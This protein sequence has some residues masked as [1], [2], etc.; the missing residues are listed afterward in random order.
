MPLSVHLKLIS[1]SLHFFYMILYKAD[2]FLRQTTSKSPH[3]STIKVLTVFYLP[4]FRIVVNFDFL[5]LLFVSILKLFKIRQCK[6]SYIII[7]AY[8]S[9]HWL[10]VEGSLPV[11]SHAQLN[12]GMFFKNSPFQL[13]KVKGKKY[14]F[15]N[16]KIK[17]Q[18]LSVSTQRYFVWFCSQ[19]LCYSFL[20]FNL[21]S[22]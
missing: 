19:K 16:W 18:D 10:C 8:L 13:P 20:Q 14:D 6:L 4:H 9:A 1:P 7:F 21:R 11:G 15:H 3:V 5:A 2:L 17:K 12:A 22:R